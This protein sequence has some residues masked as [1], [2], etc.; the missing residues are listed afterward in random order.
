MLA[1]LNE[2]RIVTYPYTLTDLRFDN[3]NTS[4]PKD[5][6][7]DIIQSFNLVEVQ[8]LPEPTYNAVYEYLGRV[9][10]TK[11]ESG[12]VQ[13][14]VVLPLSDERV[15]E[16]IANKVA[17]NVAQAKQLLV[18]SDW[19]ELPSVRNIANNYL[20]NANEWDTYRVALR[21]IVISKAEDAEFPTKPNS[22]WS[23]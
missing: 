14:W 10:P 16:N 5:I 19:S 22:I 20:A 6:P 8:V 3:Q 13:G 17:A 21:Q 11:T 15:I 4:F 2:G 1:L 9:T 7:V 18:D 23:A 12:W